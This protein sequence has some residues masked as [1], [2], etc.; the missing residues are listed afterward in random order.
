MPEDHKTVINGLLIIWQGQ[1]WSVIDSSSGY[2][3][4]RFPDENDARKFARQHGQPESKRKDGSVRVGSDGE[5]IEALEFTPFD[6]LNNDNGKKRKRFENRLPGRVR[7]LGLLVLA[8]IAGT[9]FY[10]LGTR[11]TPLPAIE[12]TPV[13]VPAY[14]AY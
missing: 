12:A 2:V 4:G 6:V 11:S 5:L 7:K 9:L 10:T 1:S 14:A 3:L 8:L 13:A